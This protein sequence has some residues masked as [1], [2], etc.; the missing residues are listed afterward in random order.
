MQHLRSAPNY[1][2]VKS[3]TGRGDGAAWCPECKVRESGHFKLREGRIVHV[4]KSKHTRKRYGFDTDKHREVRQFL[5]EL[6]EVYERL[7]R[8]R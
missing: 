6:A 4:G 2:G 7:N 5:A 3:G 1:P 8:T